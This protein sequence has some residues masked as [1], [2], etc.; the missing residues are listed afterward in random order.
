MKIGILTHPLLRNYGGILQNYALQKILIELGHEVYTINIGKKK[1]VTNW[2]RQY[3]VYV[4]KLL[5]GR[6]VA[7]PLTIKQQNIVMQHTQRFVRNNIN[8]TIPLLW[9]NE[10]IQKRYRF[11]TYIVGSDQVWRPSFVKRIEDM[12]FDFIKEE[13]V[14]RIAFAASFGVDE[15][16]FT[17]KQENNCSKLAKKFDAISVREDS[18][19]FLCENYF[20]VQA[21]HILDPTLLL[22]RY[23]YEKLIGDVYDDKSTQLTSY[24]LDLS[25]NKKQIIE[26]VANKL[27]LKI[28]FIGNPNSQKQ[29]ISYLERIIP[30]VE[31]WLDGFRKAKFVV[32]DSFHGVVFSLIFNK[33]FLCIG[34]KRR[35]MTRFNSLLKTFDLEDRLISPDNNQPDS[36]IYKIDNIIQT[37]ID[38]E[39]IQL[40]INNEKNK[41]INFLKEALKLNK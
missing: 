13:D 32:T 24:I 16:L 17:K 12:F 8:T 28:D 7:P 1:P 5:L 14:K 39:R 20:N 18:G 15:W 41:S 10:N 33:P 9:V 2:I 19:L 30:P 31:M 11:D 22:N 37:K 26:H 40:I 29:D 27:N 6:S 35:G 34:N 3:I 38:F 36:I 21:N 23:D 25:D 4:I